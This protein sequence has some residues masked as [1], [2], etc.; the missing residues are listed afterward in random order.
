MTIAPSEASG[1]A[2]PDP[3]S[4]YRLV[5][6]LLSFCMFAVFFNNFIIA[7]LITD[8]AD[9]LH[10]SVGAAGLLITV[11]A[12][13]GGVFA[14]V[15][16]PWL[17]RLGRRRVIA[18]S[19]TLLAVATMASA[20]APTFLLM[21][22]CRLIAGLAVAG[23]QPSVF[24]AVGDYVPYEERGRAM[25]WLS[26]ANL[27][28]GVLGIPAGAFLADLT[29]WRATFVAIGA[30]TAVGALVFTMYFPRTRVGAPT[31][32]TTGYRAD[33]ADIF[34]NRFANI[35]LLSNLL[36]ALGAFAWITFMGAFFID[37][38]GTSKTGVG[39]ALSLGS[40]G[41]LIGAN[42]GGRLSDR[43]GKKRV[44]IIGG[45]LAPIF[46]VIEAVVL[47]S[48][49]FNAFMHFPY[50]IL[51]GAR[52][53]PSMALMT[54]IIPEKRGAVMA[55]NSAGSQFGVMAGSALGGLVVATGGYSALGIAASAVLVLSAVILYWIDEG[56]AV[57][58]RQ[59]ATV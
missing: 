17:D 36:M 29:S 28:A 23:L 18:A 54:A 51:L 48:F 42:I 50:A 52:T 12:L 24:A 8:I 27:V 41:V 55:I 20:L 32:L 10:V 59:V 9:D 1:P 21:I 34:R 39:V 47:V 30:M 49:W 15:V 37:E 43:S 56:K 33:Y 11:Y 6:P 25:G 5:L 58:P 45:L 13:S 31:P 16:A 22:V 35:M 2:A 19:I 38:F 26:T 53:S 46:L 14:L 57:A 7:P 44:I 4:F 40:A 3:P